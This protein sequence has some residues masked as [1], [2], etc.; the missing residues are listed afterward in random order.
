MSAVFVPNSCGNFSSTS[1]CS[2][3]KPIHVVFIS[4]P[5]FNS[6]NYPQWGKLNK[7]F[8]VPATPT[9]Y[10]VLREEVEWATRNDITELYTLLLERDSNAGPL[11]TAH[12]GGGQYCTVPQQPSPSLLREAY[13]SQ[14]NAVGSCPLSWE[15]TPQLVFVFICQYRWALRRVLTWRC[16]PS[17][18]L[19]T[20]N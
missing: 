9:A 14:L 20:K 19:E 16:P 15:T 10:T 13:S 18:R 1:P 7:A 5:R 8:H 2:V 4:R 3:Q 17:V 11:L 12:G 6:F